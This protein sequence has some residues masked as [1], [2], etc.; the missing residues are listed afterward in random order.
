VLQEAV[1]IVNFAKAHTLNSR[2]FA[3]LCE[4]T[5]ADRKSLPLPSEVRWLSRCIKRL[6]ELKK[7]SPNRWLSGS[8]PGLY[9]GWTLVGCFLTDFHGVPNFFKTSGGMP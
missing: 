8:V 9:S 4:E 7:I 2:L 3:V 6:F 5:Q 1:N